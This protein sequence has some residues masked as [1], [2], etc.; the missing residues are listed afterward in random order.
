MV[1]GVIRNVCGDAWNE[2]LDGEHDV[3]YTEFEIYYD[4]HLKVI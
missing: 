3:I 4:I 2:S 1:K